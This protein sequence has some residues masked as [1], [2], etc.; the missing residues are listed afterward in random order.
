MLYYL[1][2][3]IART[4]YSNWNLYDWTIYSQTE[5]VGLCVFG[6]AAVVLA[7]TQTLNRIDG[8]ISAVYGKV[9]VQASV[10]HEDMGIVIS[11][12]TLWTKLFGAI[13][14]AVDEYT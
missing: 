13:S 10:P 5:T 11:N 3:E 6:L 1:S 4:Y 14:T 7:W 8:D 9:M 12:L 2:A